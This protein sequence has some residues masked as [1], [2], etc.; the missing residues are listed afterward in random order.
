MDGAGKTAVTVKKS[1][2]SCEERRQGTFSGAEETQEGGQLLELTTGRSPPS[3]SP[4]SD[5]YCN[6]C[7]K[8]LLFLVLLYWRCSPPH[9]LVIGSYT[10]PHTLSVLLQHI[11]IFNAA[12]TL[13]CCRHSQGCSV[14]SVHWLLVMY[15]TE[16]FKTFQSG[17]V[18]VQ[19]SD[20][21]FGQTFILFQQN[22][23]VFMKTHN[24]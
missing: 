21:S 12:A 2:F 23:V 24:L 20:C 18:S 14:G 3:T 15:F 5:T 6:L 17:W 13:D 22:K 8:L 10:L 1:D 19:V 11:A 7:L 16:I 4:Y 9:F